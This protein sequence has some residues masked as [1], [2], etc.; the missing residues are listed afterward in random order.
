MGVG[1][2][3]A[4]QKC[5]GEQSYWI[6]YQIF[7]LDSTGEGDGVPCEKERSGHA[8]CLVNCGE[9]TLLSNWILEDS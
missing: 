8:A 2:N 5:S 7:K 6:D 4:E 9:K 1:W 3:L